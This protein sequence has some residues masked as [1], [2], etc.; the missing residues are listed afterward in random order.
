MKQ[1]PLQSPS[2]AYAERGF[3]EWLDI[4]GYAPT[5]VYNLPNAV[6]E[7]L[8]WMETKKRTQLQQIT[9]Q[10]ITD[11]YDHLR[12]RENQTRGG[13]LSNAYLNK[14]QQAIKL[15]SDYLRQTGRITLPLIELNT[16]DKSHECI[17]VLTIAEIKLLYQVADHLP[18]DGKHKKGREFYEAL[19]YRD[20]AML[21][22]FYGC[23]LRRNE[24]VQLDKSDIDFDRA[25][26]HVRKGKNYK[27]RFVPITKHGIL[28]LQNYLYDARPV[29]LQG[30]K[31]E[32]L[33]ISAKGKRIDGQMLLLRLKYLI[34]LT[35][36]ATLQQ[37]KVGLH[38][39]RHS[40]ATHLLTNG[41]ALERIKEFLGH[42]SLESTQIYTHLNYENDG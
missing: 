15:F 19:G 36:N 7:L 30:S 2:Y 29:L 12:E 17:D 5:T 37:K 8:H 10:H 31:A 27:E 21:T 23:G 24:G 39:L 38:T 14:H 11:Y 13:G 26:L 25:L 6:R 4:L 34:E 9:S 16:E 32:A 33:L 3:K 35:E 42:S 18:T 40:I 22:L 20:K 1:L 41:M 28:H